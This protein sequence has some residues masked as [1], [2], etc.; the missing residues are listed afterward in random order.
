M[1]EIGDRHPDKRQWHF[2]PNIYRGVE[3]PLNFTFYELDS[4]PSPG[5]IIGHNSPAVTEI[6]GYRIPDQLLVWDGMG[7]SAMTRSLYE[8]RYGEAR[9]E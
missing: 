8:T 9:G 6:N 3:Y 5:D 2:T 1:K 4:E 7:V